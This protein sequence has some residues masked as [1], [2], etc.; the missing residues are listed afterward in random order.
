MLQAGAGF[1]LKS[2]K[3]LGEKM[4]LSRSV[5]GQLPPL[6][7]LLEIEGMPQNHRLHC[8]SSVFAGE[9][10]FVEGIWPGDLAAMDF[11]A[12]PEMFGSGASFTGDGWIIVPPSHTLE[13]VFSLRQGSRLLI[14]NAL[15]FLLAHSDDA[16]DPAFPAYHRRLHQVLKGIAVS[17][18]RIPTRR[19]AEICVHYYHNLR[20]GP[21]LSLTQEPKPAAP[22]FAS[23]EQYRDY[24][25][26]TVQAALRNAADPRRGHA[27]KP[28]AT[29]SRGYDSP[30]GCSI[31]RAAGCTE[32]ITHG[33][34]RRAFGVVDPDSGEAVAEALGMDVKVIDRK[35]YLAR[36]DIEAPEAEFLCHGL[37][38]ADVNFLSFETLLR[39]R[40]LFSGFHGDTVWD[41][42]KQ[43]NGVIER[44]DTSGASMGEFRRRVDFFHIPVPFIGVLRHAE[45]K[46]IAETAPMRPFALDNDYDRPI[47]RR[48]AEEAGVPRDAFGME[49]KAASMN[50]FGLNLGLDEPFADGSRQALRRFAAGWR[51]APQQRLYLRANALVAY[52]VD[53]VRLVLKKTRIAIRLKVEAP[54][55]SVLSTLDLAT[56]DTPAT[57]LALHWAMAAIV[58][59]YAA[60]ASPADEPAEPLA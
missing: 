51:P 37:E 12:A 34:A 27:Y 46:A 23:F 41:R 6:A 42:H 14:S 59:R 29:A 17:P 1:A 18:I 43:P 53:F 13:P 52:G 49:K 22:A 19:G 36:A 57:V 9:N 31:A 3:S 35:A 11:A 24:L 4:R 44:G 25:L 45:I 15:P 32:V 58:A 8:G 21:D 40:V 39:H 50:F 7:W 60:A 26:R 2:G 20:V 38:G 33:F 28:I 55:D 54:I 56:L 10:G 47:P 16:L 30:A 48:I 5:R